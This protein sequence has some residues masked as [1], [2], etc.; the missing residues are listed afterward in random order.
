MTNIGPIPL[1]NY[2]EIVVLT[3]AG[4]SVA[5]GLPTYRGVGGIWNQVSVDGHATA[6]AVQS[7]PERVWRFFTELRHQ[8]AQ[9]VL[10][11]AKK[12]G[13]SVKFTG[14]ERGLGR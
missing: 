4:I 3:G 10:M 12:R 8:V 9:A 2:R 6:A 5:S 14:E 1:A 11:I 7:D 13:N